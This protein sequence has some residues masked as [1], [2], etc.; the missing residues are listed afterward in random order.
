MLTWDDEGGFGVE[1]DDGN[2]YS[3]MEDSSTLVS[4]PRQVS[5]L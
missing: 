2:A 1:Y 3:D 5:F 4:Q